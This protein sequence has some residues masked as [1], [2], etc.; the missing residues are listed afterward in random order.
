MTWRKRI[1]LALGLLSVV[2]IWQALTVSSFTLALFWNML[3]TFILGMFVLTAFRESRGNRREAKGLA[4]AGAKRRARRNEKAAVRADKAAAVTAGSVAK[5]SSAT[6]RS[7]PDSTNVPESAPSL[8][9]VA[10]E[11]EAGTAATRTFAS[12]ESGK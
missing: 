3:N 12:V 8:T 6:R 10:S 9:A 5:H 7:T 2:G 1:G 11:F 4:P